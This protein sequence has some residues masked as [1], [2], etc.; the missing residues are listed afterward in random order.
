M[1]SRHVKYLLDANTII[2]LLDGNSPELRD[3]V[4]D[5][6]EGEIVIS[7]IAFAEVAVGSWNGKTPSLTALDQFRNRMTIKPFDELAAKTYAQLPFKRGSFDRLI[8]AHALSLNLTLITD[9]LKHFGDIPD[10]RVENWTR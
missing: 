2:L 4:T 3:R 10:L 5:C 1:D 7:A 6:A 8:A 9:N